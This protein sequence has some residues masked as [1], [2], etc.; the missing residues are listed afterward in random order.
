M[1]AALDWLETAGE[2]RLALQLAGT[3]SQ[4]WYLAGR[5]AEGAQTLARALRASDESTPERGKALRAAAVMAI[6]SGDVAAGRRYAE[7]AGAV[8]HELGDQWGLAHI[9]FVLGHAAADEGSFPAAERHLEESTRRFRE[10][11]DD[12][13]AQLAAYNLAEVIALQDQHRARPL[14]EQTIADARR[15]SD[16]RIVALSLVQLAAISA[17]DGRLDDAVSMLAESL[18]LFQGLGVRV[19]TVDAISRFASVLARKGE[20][21]V[22]AQLLASSEALREEIGSTSLP[23][24]AK[25]NEETLLAIRPQLDEPVFAGAWEQ[26]RALSLDEA[27]ALAL[28]NTA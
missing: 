24:A 28:E 17:D 25:R 11:G 4:F 13:Y 26:G 5:P 14:L 20:V 7:Q 19:E 1:R 27:V 8:C 18:D 21:E 16:R 15:V 12:H 3:L 23:F 22:A 10:L 2:P 9:D 6:T